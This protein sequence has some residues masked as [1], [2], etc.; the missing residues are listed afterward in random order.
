MLI[1]P[2]ILTDYEI[3]HQHFT[4]IEYI[5]LFP[6]SLLPEAVFSTDIVRGF[7]V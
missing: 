1:V 4:L 2:F 3:S 7:R 5:F 6:S